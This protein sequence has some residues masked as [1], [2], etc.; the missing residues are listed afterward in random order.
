M[1]ALSEENYISQ[2]FLS[3][4]TGYSLGL[5]NR[6]IKKLTDKGYLDE[7]KHFTETAK[8]VFLNHSPRNAIILA[9]GFGM[10]MVPINMDI[11][12]ALLEVRGEILIERLIRQL[13]A[14]GVEDIY[15]VVG[16]MKETI[17]T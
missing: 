14:A 11:P 1:L 7:E 2:R 16:F 3:E 4:Q 15:V 6:C 17:Q 8:N 10:R 9:A 12:K 5:V 13:Q